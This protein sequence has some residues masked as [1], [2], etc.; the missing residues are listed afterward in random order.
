M[1]LIKWTKH[2][3]TVVAVVLCMS[4]GIF[5]RNAIEGD[6]DDQMM[7]VVGHVIAKTASGVAAE[8]W[9]S[10]NP[11]SESMRKLLGSPSSDEC[12]IIEATVGKMETW[13]DN[14]ITP[15]PDTCV[16]TN[17][18]SYLIQLLAESDTSAFGRVKMRTNTVKRVN[19]DLFVVRNSMD[20]GAFLGGS[21]LVS[22][23]FRSD[24]IQ[25]PTT[26][27]AAETAGK[28]IYGIFGM[29]RFGNG[30]YQECISGTLEDSKLHFEHD[31]LEV[32]AWAC[33][34]NTVAGKTEECLYQM[35]SPVTGSVKL[36][37]S[38]NNDQFDKT[39][40]AGPTAKPTGIVTLEFPITH[41]T[42]AELYRCAWFDKTKGWVVDVKKTLCAGQYNTVTKR[43]V[44]HCR[45]LGFFA[46]A[47]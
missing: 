38:A 47:Y 35:T 10:S 2:V 17:T 45:N 21:G 16:S 15:T 7:D 1:G 24:S 18:Q 33:T 46:A 20:D 14:C 28:D 13:N 37:P 6:D 41:E 40:I 36:V 9:D 22:A 11:E 31:I 42:N 34:A 43:L 3:V 4:V 19:V 32:G 27:S 8:I 29:I 26:L 12:Q 30:N 5:A 25:T 39:S 44:C 23:Y